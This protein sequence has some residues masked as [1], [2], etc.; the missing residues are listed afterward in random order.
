MFVHSLGVLDLCTCL[1]T[2]IQAMTQYKAAQ[3][4][5]L[6]PGPGQ[7]VT[8]VL[9]DVQGST[10]LWWVP[11]PGGVQGFVEHVFQG[12]LVLMGVEVCST[13]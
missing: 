8:L 9:T 5:K 7:Q 2:C 11:G 13:L 4:K 3:A 10:E 12:L 6:P 1:E